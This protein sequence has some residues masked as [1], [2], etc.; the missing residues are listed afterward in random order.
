MG[1]TPREGVMAQPAASKQDWIGISRG[2]LPIRQLHKVEDY[3]SVWLAIQCFSF[4]RLSF[5]LESAAIRH[6]RAH[7]S[8]DFIS[9]FQIFSVSAFQICP[10]AFAQVFRRIA[11][12]TP[13]EFRS[14]L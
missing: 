8:P 4:Q 2:G 10:S 13:T 11:G 1:V 7:H 6:P 3:V 5:S 14:A 12:V 9:V